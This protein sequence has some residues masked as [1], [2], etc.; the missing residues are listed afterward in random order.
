MI[1]CLLFCRHRRQAYLPSHNRNLLWYEFVGKIWLSYKLY[2]PVILTVI[3]LDL[4]VITS[5]SIH[6]TKLYEALG[7]CTELEKHG[8]DCRLEI[9]LIRSH[10]IG[11]TFI[12][13]VPT[14]KDFD[15]IN[16]YCHWQIL[17]GGWKRKSVETF[18]QITE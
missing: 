14:L 10:Y 3:V 7:Y 4:I 1:Q 2:F 6:Y 13:N 16:N 17:L 9:G 8:V 11:R 12:Q 15:P 18:V 5:Y